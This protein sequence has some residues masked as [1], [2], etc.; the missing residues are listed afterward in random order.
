MLLTSGA[1]ISALMGMELV[2]YMYYLHVHRFIKEKRE[3]RMTLEVDCAWMENYILNELNEE[4][5]RVMIKKSVRMEEK[6][7]IST[8]E[9]IRKED[10]QRWVSYYIYYRNIEELNEE[11]REHVEYILRQIEKKLKV[12][13]KEDDNRIICISRFGKNEIKTTYKPLIVYTSL[14]IAKNW[15]Y[16]KMYM[17]GF[18]RYTTKKSK[19]TYMHY[20]KE[21]NTKTTMFIHG[22]GFGIMPYQSYIEELREKSNL[23]I[24]ILPNISNMEYT[25]YFTNLKDE[26][27]FPPYEVWREDIGAILNKHGIEKLDIVGHSFGTI[28]MGILL[29]DKEINRR[30]E[31]RIFID[32]VCFIEKSYKIYNYIDEPYVG[33]NVWTNTVFNKLIYNDVYVRYVMQR[34]LYGPEFWILDYEKMEKA[35]I[36][37]SMDDKIV[38]SNAL[39]KRLTKKGVPC[40]TAAE[41][42]HSD[43]FFI[44]GF[45]S[46]LNTLSYYLHIV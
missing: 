1:V 18:K 27:L 36:V 17:S 25:S 31:K 19:I 26:E 7:E 15:N 43:I 35:L 10:M 21:E 12:K 38:P 6:E 3:H 28:I 2:N 34:Y 46:I 40:I 45:K 23:I 9:E 39:H 11:E 29:K 8:I 4:E 16:M 44:S 5:L 20:Y 13:F 37:L 33:E 42:K 22:L 24:P 14:N 32:P 30:V 41:A